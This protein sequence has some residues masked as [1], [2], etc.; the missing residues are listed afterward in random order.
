M[1]ADGPWLADGLVLA[2]GG[3]CLARGAMDANAFFS[4]VVR[5]QPERGQVVCD[6]GPYA[7][8]RHPG[9]A[10]A[11]LFELGSPLVLGSTWAAGPAAVAGMVLVVRTVLEDRVLRRDLAGYAAYAARVRWR[12]V[13]G[14]W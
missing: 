1:T 4:T 14:A 13:P 3:H 2:L 11:A 8:V 7:V 12:L 6:R 9:Y 5:L 10:G